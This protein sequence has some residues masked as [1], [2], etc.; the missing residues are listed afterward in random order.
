MMESEFWELRRLKVRVRVVCLLLLMLPLTACRSTSGMRGTNV[1]EHYPVHGVVVNL[2]P[3]DGEIELKHGAISGLMEAMTMPYKVEDPA[4]LSEMHP[5]DAITATIECERD[6]TGPLNLRLKNIVIVAQARPDYK[7]AVQYNVP[8]PGDA[9]PD[10]K[11]LNQFGHTIEMKQFRGKVVAL[12]FIYTRCP[13]PDYCPRMTQ[14]F[15]VIDK[16]LRADP[17]LSHETHLLS[18]SFDPAYDTPRMLKSYGETYI[19]AN[20]DAA[21]QH[22]D[23]AAPPT[24]ELVKMEQYFDVGVTPGESGMLQHSLSTV[25]IGKDGK[26]VA[27]WPT[28]DWSV[29]ELLAKMKAA[30]G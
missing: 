7:P 27:F 25:I 8:A 13:L 10:F 24:D 30:A 15:A 22:W 6:A 28:N 3:A 2:Y 4:A 9:V 21:F 29:D 18:V 26:I 11:L 16:A 23:F 14:N 12:T 1:T 5:G 17:K 19:G 20:A